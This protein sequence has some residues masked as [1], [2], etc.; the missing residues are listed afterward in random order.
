MPSPSSIRPFFRYAALITAVSVGAMLAAMAIVAAAIALGGPRDLPPL[1]SINEPFKDRVQTDVPPAQRYTA[2]DGTVLAW[3]AYGPAGSTASV[4]LR[5]VVLLHGSSARGESNHVLAQALAAEGYAVAS[6]DMRG[7]GASGPRGRAAYIGQLEDDLED[8][9]RSV[10]HTGPQ[11]LM[12]FSAGGGFALRFAAS[13]RQ[14]LF[15]DYVLLSPFLHH[16]APT[17]RPDSGGWAF[18]GIPRMIALT[19]LNRLGI[20]G[21][22][23]LPVMS[24]ALSEAA[25]NVLTPSYSYTVASNFRPH[26]D[27]QADIRRAR[28]KICIVAG[29]ADELFYAD[30]FASVFADAGKT[31]PVT[32]LPGIDHINLI[33][34][35]AAV[36]VIAQSCQT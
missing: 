18:V 13:S 35:A 9:L 27:Y 28:G 15:S 14:E 25:G 32:L 21:L 29:Q 31:V 4:P 23:D 34:D 1:A 20:T 2:R 33:L 26:D 24:F 7:H 12:G 10:P 5:R 16:E 8:F 6:L 3:H 36:R 19:L 22:N 11:T 17:S 30:R